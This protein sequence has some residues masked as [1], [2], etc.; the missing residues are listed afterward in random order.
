MP[1]IGIVVPNLEGGGGVPT[2]AEFLCEVI[3][4]STE[5]H[6]KLVS[7][8]VSWRDECSI[9]LTRPSSWFQGITTRNGEWNGR[10]YIHVGSTW[11]ELEFMRFR[12]RQVL[13]S[14]LDDCDLIQV[15][16]GNPAW[17][18]SVMGEGRPVVAQVA[19]LAANER[20]AKARMES[21]AIGAWRYC[22][23]YRFGFFI[24]VK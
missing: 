13:S 18:L 12:P 23:T 6:F 5:F 3:D 17:A 1:K 2:V 7:L 9:R 20:K 16:S 8:A 19:T 10:P 11:V 4:N 22:T 14:V 24:I 15:V 21:G